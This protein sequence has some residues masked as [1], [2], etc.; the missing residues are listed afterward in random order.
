MARVS[1]E[2]GASLAMC[3]A[4][5]C[6]SCLIEQL[7]PEREGDVIGGGAARSSRG[8]GH[9]GT[10]LIG[11][12]RIDAV[13]SSQN[14]GGRVDIVHSSTG[15]CSCLC[16]LLLLLHERM[17]G[18]QRA[19]IAAA[20]VDRG[21]VQQRQMEAMQLRRHPHSACTCTGIGSASSRR[22]SRSSSTRGSSSG[23]S[24]SRSP[25]AGWRALP[26]QMA[27]WRSAC[28]AIRCR[29][30]RMRVT[31]GDVRSK[32]RSMAD[33]RCAVWLDER[34]VKTQRQRPRA[35]GGARSVSEGDTSDTHTRASS[36]L[37]CTA[38]IGWSL[39]ICA[40]LCPWSAVG[41]RS[42]LSGGS[43]WTQRQ[44]SGARSETVAVWGVAVSLTWRCQPARCRR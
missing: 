28:N 44:G 4:C 30:T 33:V 14:V 1:S 10:G 19:G 36:M 31:H 3:R 15:E 17:G 6:V 29:L 25:A 5:V 26:R 8:V 34:S 18:G 9:N 35:G 13:I 12:H 42:R 22:A 27:S 38:L 11:A 39:W 24:R 37:D 41:E 23:S 16:R 21:R 40:A 32:R 7:V 2:R 20:A 43:E